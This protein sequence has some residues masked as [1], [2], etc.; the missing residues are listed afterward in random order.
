MTGVCGHAPEPL[1]K[2]A[3]RVYKA[4]RRAEFKGQLVEVSESHPKGLVWIKTGSTLEQAIAEKEKQTLKK[5][6]K[7]K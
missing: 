1:S 5:I 2:D 7:R 6:P 3:R 4:M